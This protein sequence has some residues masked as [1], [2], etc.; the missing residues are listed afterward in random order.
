MQLNL[1]PL[2]TAVLMTTLVGAFTFNHAFADETV[3]EKMSEAGNDTKRA[4]KK[5]T[6]KVKD[7]ACEMVNG[8]MKCAGKK[9]KHGVQNAGDKVEDAVD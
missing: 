1:K 3:K 2:F 8:K 4:V 9:I 5:G 6:R 7:E